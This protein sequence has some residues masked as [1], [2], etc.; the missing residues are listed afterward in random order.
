MPLLSSGVLYAQD[1]PFNPDPAT[2]F[3]DNVRVIATEKLETPLVR[4]SIRWD[5]DQREVTVLVDD[6][7]K[8]YPYPE[9]M[10]TIFDQIRPTW[11]DLIVVSAYTPDTDFKPFVLNLQTGTFALY[12]PQCGENSPDYLYTNMRDQLWVLE[13]T[14]G[15]VYLCASLTGERTPKLALPEDFEPKPDTAVT[16]SSDYEYAA[17]AGA[18]GEVYSYAFDTGE[19]KSLGLVQGEISLNYSFWT[20]DN[21]Q[22]AL[23]SRNGDQCSIYIADVTGKDDLTLAL[24][25]SPD[26][27]RIDFNRPSRLVYWAMTE[28]T[29]ENPLR[30][31]T[32]TVY[33]IETGAQHVYDYGTLCRPDYGS[34]EGIGYYR[35]V[36][37]NYRTADVVRFDVTT[38]EQEILYSGGQI[39]AVDWVSKDERFAVLLM[40]DEGRIDRLP[41]AYGG[42]WWLD[43][44][45]LALVDLTADTTLY[46]TPIRPWDESQYENISDITMLSDELLLVQIR[47][48]DYIPIPNTDAWNNMLRYESGQLVRLTE[49]KPIVKDFGELA[50]LLPG[51]SRL[52]VWPDGSYVSTALD[53]YDLV[54][55]K[56]VPVLRAVDQA[57]YSVSIAGGDNANTA[58]VTVYPIV[59]GEADRRQGMRYTVRF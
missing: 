10:L 58:I 33:E 13:V 35:A 20:G 43:K 22:V 34:D 57:Q 52:L 48:L 11:G 56:A 6:Q 54:T 50:T 26:C 16:V 19:I 7:I 31:C 18:D 42:D 51:D 28:I 41:G 8:R 38:G 23:R 46:E 53:A 45:S 25:T 3:P 29:R 2:F 17:F 32:K 4:L 5:D 14:S 15:G 40:D 21:R 27:A 36:S 44:P 47:Y 9:D 24:E 30:S 49:G 12:E 59:E 1:Q 39:E 37:N 55:G